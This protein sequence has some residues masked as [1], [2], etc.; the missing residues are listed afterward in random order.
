M[1]SMGHTRPLGVTDV[2][3]EGDC[4]GEWGGVRVTA[5]GDCEGER[6]GVRV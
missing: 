1:C 4:E 5:E 2:T 6:G 3:A